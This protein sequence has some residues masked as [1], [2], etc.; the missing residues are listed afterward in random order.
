MGRA[1]P[2]T[3]LAD[4]A[5]WGADPDAPLRELAPD[6]AGV[7]AWARWQNQVACAVNEKVGSSAL[8]RADIARGAFANEGS[9]GQQIVGNDFMPLD[10]IIGTLRFLERIDLWPTPN[11][12][13]DLGLAD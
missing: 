13:T 8:S 10:N 3:L 11:D 12:W 6:E 7:G 2:K 9:F 4:P 1:Q 5:L